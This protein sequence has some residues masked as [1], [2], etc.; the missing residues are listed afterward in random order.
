[1]HTQVQ[2]PTKRNDNTEGLTYTTCLQILN[3]KLKEPVP[4]G[5]SSFKSYSEIN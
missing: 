5:T 3:F 4:F 2:L 1:M